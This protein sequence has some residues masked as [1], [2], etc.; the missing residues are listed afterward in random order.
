MPEAHKFVS[1]EDFEGYRR[2]RRLNDIHPTHWPGA[3]Y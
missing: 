2:N 1:E 3:E